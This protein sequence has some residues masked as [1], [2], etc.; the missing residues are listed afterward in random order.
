VAN[1]LTIRNLSIAPPVQ[2]ELLSALAVSLLEQ[3]QDATRP[4][5]FIE[6]EPDAL[7]ARAGRTAAAQDVR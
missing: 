2:R 3:E 6:D 4:F 1:A 5:G 7:L